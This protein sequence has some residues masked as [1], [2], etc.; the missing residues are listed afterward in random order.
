MHVFYFIQVC[1]ISSHMLMTFD[2]CNG[3]VVLQDWDLSLRWLKKFRCL[4][5]F[6]FV[7]L[8]SRSL[9]ASLFQTSFSLGL[10]WWL[11]AVGSFL[12]R[13]HLFIQQIMNG[14]YRLCRALTVV[15]VGDTAVSTKKKYKVLSAI[16]RSK[17]K[18]QWLSGC[19]QKPLSR[20]DIKA[21]IG[22]TRNSQSCRYQE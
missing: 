13:F 2:I 16:Q 1:S 19:L 12:H 21:E 4:Q 6:Y 3:T 15:G 8:F 22:I 9:M 10:G 18:W 11:L 17:I 14:M 7:F 5:E 20:G